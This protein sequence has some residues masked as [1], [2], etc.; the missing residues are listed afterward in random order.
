[1]G[2]PKSRMRLAKPSSRPA[3][4]TAFSSYRVADRAARRAS[5]TYGPS[6][7]ATSSYRVEDGVSHRSG[8]SP[9]RYRVQSLHGDSQSIPVFGQNSILAA[10]WDGVSNA[11]AALVSSG[12]C[13]QNR[14]S[15]AR[16]ASRN[17]RTKSYRVADRVSDFIALIPLGVC[18][19]VSPT[20]FFASPWSAARSK[21]A[22]PTVPNN[23]TSASFFFARVWHRAKSF[24]PRFLE[25]G[26][27]A[28]QPTHRLLVDPKCSRALTG[29][30]AKGV[31]LLVDAPYCGADH[32]LLGLLQS[33]AWGIRF[34]F[35]ARWLTIESSRSTASVSW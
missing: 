26:D 14:L 24:L 20:S 11:A 16:Y 27:G 5:A 28:L 30:D 13:E 6:G 19:S 35:D 15:Q 33:L 25:L 1:M 8:A 18:L 22:T 3:N 21:Q 7:S 32:R 23:P 31:P 29:S 12:P 2:R 10:D 9:G 17:S 34:H 4:S